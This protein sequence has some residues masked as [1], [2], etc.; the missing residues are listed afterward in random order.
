MKSIIF[1]LAAITT[2][3]TF[4]A[5]AEVKLISKNQSDITIQI[6]GKDAKT[7]QAILENASLDGEA[8]KDD[9]SNIRSVT[10]DKDSC[11][12]LASGQLHTSNDVE[13][14]YTKDFNK[15]LSSLKANQA[16]LSV[17]A[18][19]TGNG[20]N[21]TE[22]D[23]RLQRALMN[24]Q[25]LEIEGVNVKIERNLKSKY[26]VQRGSLMVLT[27]TAE[28]SELKLRCRT[29]VELEMGRTNFAQNTCSLEAVVTK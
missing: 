26:D 22:F 12:I 10:C 4:S 18:F 1:A 14:Y 7:L 6:T 15:T 21:I 29:S 9:Y 3:S 27:A 2:F 28:L 16:L 25:L 8:A 23:G 17:P 24:A 11:T 13:D 20:G 5:Q 19:G